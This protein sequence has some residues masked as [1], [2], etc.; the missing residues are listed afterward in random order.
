MQMSKIG[1]IAFVAACGW[2]PAD[3]DSAACSNF[4]QHEVRKP[5][6]K[7]SFISS[8]QKGD[9]GFHSEASAVPEE[10]SSATAFWDSDGFSQKLLLQH[11]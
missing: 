4:I 1:Q 8:P 3:Y 5:K 7:E 11:Q 9:V 10:A 6:F 2:R